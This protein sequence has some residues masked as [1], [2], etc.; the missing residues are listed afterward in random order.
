MNRIDEL[1]KEI[2]VGSELPEFS[3]GD[4]LK[5]HLKVVEGTRERI[6]VFEGLCI[7]RSNRALNSTFTMRKISNGEGVERVFPLYSPLIDKLEVIRRGDVRRAKLYYIRKRSGKK[8]RIAEKRVDNKIEEVK[9]SPSEESSV[10]KE[11]PIK[12][13]DPVKEKEAVKK[14]K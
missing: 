3:S 11:E 4:E 12:K 13:K 9:V 6:Q 7:A 5:V 10:K 14:E 8:A 2:T 1:Q